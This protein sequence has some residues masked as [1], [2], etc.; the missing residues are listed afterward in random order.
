MV[1]VIGDRL[2]GESFRAGKA[3]CVDWG[4]LMEVAAREMFDLTTS[5]VLYSI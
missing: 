4:R 3:C 2:E 1:V 5:F